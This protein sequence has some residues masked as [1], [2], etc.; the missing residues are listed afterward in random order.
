[1]L[2]SETARR[3]LYELDSSISSK[4][5]TSVK[6][7]SINPFLNRPKADIKKLKGSRN[8]D[9]YRLR[10]GDF[11]VIYTI[12]NNDVKITEILRRDKAYD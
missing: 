2:I 12:S 1:M 11:R 5:K 4:I 8:P 7:L 3:Q 10:V 9:F 6:E